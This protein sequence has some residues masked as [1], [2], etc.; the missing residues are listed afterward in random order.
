MWSFISLIY[1]PGL[2]GDQ[3]KEYKP[4]L[5]SARRC[6]IDTNDP[7]AFLLCGRTLGNRSCAHQAQSKDV[8]AFD[9]SNSRR[10]S[11][12]ILNHKVVKPVRDPGS[13]NL[14]AFGSVV[15]IPTILVFPI[16]KVAAPFHS[17]AFLL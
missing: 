2:R 17:F 13:V 16:N 7:P 4:R 12:R 3:R 5:R 9:F 8:L 1:S 10:L 14:L 11:W 15:N 6:R